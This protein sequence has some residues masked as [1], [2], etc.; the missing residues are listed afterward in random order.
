[1]F[2]KKDIKTGL[3]E[4]PGGITAP[5]GF[6][7]AG[8]ACG[9]K[10]SGKKDLALIYSETPAAGAAVFTTNKFKAAQV[11]LSM[12]KIKDHNIR[13]IL[14]NSGNAN[15]CTGEKGMEDARELISFL[16]EKLSVDESEI[17]L[18]STGI[19]GELLPVEKMKKGI[20]EITP[21]LSKGG[22]QDAA[23]AILTTD[24]RIKEIAFRFLLPSSRRE[25]KIGAMAK[26][27][28]M[29]HPDLATM[30]A[31]I[32]TDISIDKSLLQSALRE[33]VNK[34]FNRISVDGD[35]STNDTVFLLANGRAGNKK[36]KE[37]DEDY[38]AFLDALKETAVFLAKSIVLDG[39]GATR[40][41]TIRI[42]QARNEEEAVIAARQI[43]N[44][45]LVK[46]ACFGGDPNWGRITMALGSSKIDFDENK[47][48]VA[49]NKVELFSNGKPS[50]HY[51]DSL[52]DLIKTGDILIEINLNQGES[53]AEFWTSD[54]S[55]DYIKINAEYHT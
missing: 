23:E 14:I 25:V 51:K 36:I 16:A 8:I 47:V 21:L 15:S 50:Y 7:A 20:E 1:M 44:S 35:Q 31:F 4:I 2:E 18:S 46:T 6:L 33:A 19:I 38:Y 39:E 29:I 13:A 10:K 9:I 3:E 53:T 43:A 11:L 27:S 30:L 26:G 48:S 12:E 54:L 55:Y 45:N 52:S 17:H 41:I 5:V 32:T 42:I 49:I 24:K 37:K 22:S 40:F 34:S 28:G